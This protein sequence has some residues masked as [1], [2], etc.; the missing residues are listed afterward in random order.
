MVGVSWCRL[1]FQSS[2]CEV[3]ARLEI[4]PFGGRFNVSQG[5]IKLCRFRRNR[6][7]RLPSSWPR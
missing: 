3:A 1:S 5:A 6:I 2:F 4:I 7:A